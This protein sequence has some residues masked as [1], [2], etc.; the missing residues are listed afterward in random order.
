M[1]QTFPLRHVP[2]GSRPPA[3]SS[4]LWPA[5]TD[6]N[7][8]V[9]WYYPGPDADDP[10]GGGRK[11][12]SRFRTRNLNE[13]DLA[14]NIRRLQTN[15]EI[16]NEQLAAKGYPVMTSLNA[17]ETR[18]AAQRQHAHPRQPDEVS[19]QYQGGTQQNPV[20]I[21]GDMVLILDHNMQLLWAWD[22]FAHQDLSREATLDEI[23]TT[24]P[25][26]VRRS[27]RAFHQAN[28]WL[29]A[30]A[31][32]MT[33]DGNIVLSERNQDWVLK[34]N[35]KNGQGDGSISWRWD[36]TAISPS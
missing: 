16:L 12:S 25:Q 7:G 8:N 29:H 36:P 24:T 2:L 33:P 17:H 3:S 26:A 11:L 34:I 4:A 31:V 22:S 30:N 18:R 32:Q 21:L 14:G 13:F 9:V 5:A 23:C 1:M 15:I 6:L 19:T 28:D 27:I 20:D 10:H 35:Y